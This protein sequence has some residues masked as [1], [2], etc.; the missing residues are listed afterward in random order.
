MGGGMAQRIETG[1]DAGASVLLGGALLFSASKL[2]LPLLLAAGWGLL[3]FILCLHLLRSVDSGRGRH[4]VRPFDVAAFEPDPSELLLDDVLAKVDEDSRV[5]R[6]F[7]PS[8]AVQAAPPDA[9]QAL[10]DAL[11]QLRRSVRDR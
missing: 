2:G 5:V 10:Y 9:S 8:P 11:A 3:G 4:A 1:V 6:L 7:D